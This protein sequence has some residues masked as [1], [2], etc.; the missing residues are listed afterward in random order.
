[1][2]R[3]EEN[4]NIGSNINK[5]LIERTWFGKV[6]AL[7]LQM[8]KDKRIFFH[9]G[10]KNTEKWI[11]KKCKFSS[12][13]CAGILRVL[14]RKENRWSTYHSYN[15]NSA[16]IWVNRHENKVVFKFDELS[17]TII[18]VEATEMAIILELVIVM[19]LK[20]KYIAF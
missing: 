16:K 4:K 7:K 9:I 14:Q 1:M 17:K 19:A 12:L 2:V 13:E 11:W 3:I 10:K 5:S 18:P 20:T 6:S 15:G 8:S